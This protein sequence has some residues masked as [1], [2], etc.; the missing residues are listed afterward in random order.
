[1][2]SAR[3]LQDSLKCSN[4]LL[5]YHL[6]ESE[7]FKKYTSKY[8]HTCLAQVFLTHK[9]NPRYKRKDN[10]RHWFVA[11]GDSS[12][13]LAQHYRLYTTIFGMVVRWLIG[14]FGWL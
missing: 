8:R 9:A 13:W 10:P 5:G 4:R 12:V 3:V 2:V 1:M 7:H 11:I 6:K 14:N